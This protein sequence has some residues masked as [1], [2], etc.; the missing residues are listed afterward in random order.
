MTAD[1]DQAQIRLLADD[2]TGALDSGAR[3]SS[4]FGPLPVGFRPGGRLPRGSY[5]LDCGTRDATADTARACNV[6]LGDFFSGAAIALRKV[7]T[8]MR[9]HTFEEVA[10]NYRLGGFRSAVFAPAFPEQGR[11]TR[12]GRQ[13][14]RQGDELADVAGP[15]ADRV[16]AAGI[17][18]VIAGTPDRVTGE[19]F[20]ICDAAT[21][22]ELAAI[23]AAGR[24]LVGPV[25]WCG[26]AG[27]AGA[28]G[29]GARLQ[30]LPQRPCLV[31]VGSH[32]ERSL[33][34]LA[35]LRDTCP[36][37]TLIA[38]R[39]DGT[40]G[41]IAADG[42]SVLGFDL[43]G[44]PPA[45]MADAVREALGAHLGT[46]PAPPAYL[47]ATGGETL[48]SI[49]EMTGA[50]TL[51]VTGEIEGGIPLSRLEGGRWDGVAVVSKS[52]AFGD[53]QTLVRLAAA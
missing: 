35:A 4:R 11:I 41:I 15:I 32:H 28:L 12:D 27:L 5:G 36:R 44:I 29:G 3:F 18:P 34:Q 7:D 42:L 22:A 16:R 38:T 1:G 47:V 9:G 2:L 52:G 49:A 43:Q 39:R 14:I 31:V 21:T 8:L 10:L 40:G 17:T 6:A 25:L 30:A 48:R 24:T 53:P 51:R 45:E 26:A 37:S 19:G 13:W 23:A 20:F 33:A 46:L 50:T